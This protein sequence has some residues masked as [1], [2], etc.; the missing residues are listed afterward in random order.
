MRTIK[1]NVVAITSIAF[2]A[3]VTMNQNSARASCNA[4]DEAA[5]CKAMRYCWIKPS[6]RTGAM[7]KAIVEDSRRLLLAE[8]INCFKQSKNYEEK[9][10]LLEDCDG[11]DNGIT[12]LGIAKMI[13]NNQQ[14]FI[15]DCIN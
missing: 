11:K 15:K 9:K 3:L 5:L 7:V 14:R 10:R 2:A 13:K 6:L 8:M 4:A 1:C 12:V